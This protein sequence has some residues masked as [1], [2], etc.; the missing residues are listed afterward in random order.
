MPVKWFTFGYRRSFTADYRRAATVDRSASAKIVERYSQK[1]RDTG[2]VRVVLYVLLNCNGPRRITWAACRGSNEMGAIA[3]PL[4]VERGPIER[5]R[6]PRPEGTL[7]MRPV[8]RNFLRRFTLGNAALER[9]VLLLFVEQAPLYVARLAAATDQKEWHAAA[10]TL[11]GSARAVG[12]WRVARAAETAEGTAHGSPVDRRN[13][14]ID[15][16]R[17]ATT[18]AVR[19]IEELFPTR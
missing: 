3:E 11:K 14:A 5:R 8:D 17:E 10:H 18:E 6:Y 2:Q 13:F 12:A 1:E 4:D 7:G 19:F 15:T 9:E 16:T